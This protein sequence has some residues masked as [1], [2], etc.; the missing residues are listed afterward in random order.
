MSD[1]PRLEVERATVRYGSLA[2]LDRFDLTVPAGE[3]VAVLG[4]SGSG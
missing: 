1:P 4:P 3:V 2:A